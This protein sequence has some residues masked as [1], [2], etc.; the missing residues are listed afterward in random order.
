MRQGGEA[1]LGLMAGI[2]AMPRLMQWR[3]H[4]AGPL[5]PVPDWSVTMAKLNPL[6]D[7]LVVLIGGDGFVGTHLAQDLL[8]R[9]ARLRIAGRRPEKA[10]GL[11]PLANLGQM[12]FAR[13]D[14]KDRRSLEAVLRGADAA[15]YLV[16]TFGADAQALQAE[17]AGAAAAIASDQGAQAFVYV[18]A[19]GAD[20]ADEE[21]LYAATKGEGEHKVREAFPAATIMRPSILFGEDDSFITMFADLVRSFPV[22]PVFGPD[23]RIQPLWVDDAARAIGNALADP[24]VHGGKVY[25][26]AG[27]EVIT[28]EALNRRIAAAQ[29]RRRTFL[30]MP[31]A[32]SALFANLP[33]TPMNA[34]QWLLLKRGSVATGA[35]PGIAELGVTPSP[36]SLFLERWMVR[37]QRHGRFTASGGAA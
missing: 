33:G 2:A 22:L 10:F 13:C 23:A 3:A 31:D 27:P 28:M 34:D 12:Q 30:P 1:L 7:R 24:A 15:A 17:G 14:V 4:P 9:G 37:Y 16:G 29:G 6:E 25:E 18:S 26:L 19:I 8:G 11:K 32:L 21:S 35:L 20:P 5:S 36:L